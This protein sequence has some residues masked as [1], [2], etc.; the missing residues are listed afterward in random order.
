MAGAKFLE[1]LSL[2]SARTMDSAPALG[3]GEAKRTCHSTSFNRLSVSSCSMDDDQKEEAKTAPQFQKIPPKAPPE[4]LQWSQKPLITREIPDQK[5][6]RSE[7]IWKELG[8]LY[9]EMVR[10]RAVNRGPFAKIIGQPTPCPRNSFW[11]DVEAW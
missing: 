5:K 11:G 1:L 6:L 10:E 7:Y 3:K 4:P 9:R 8:D 2:K